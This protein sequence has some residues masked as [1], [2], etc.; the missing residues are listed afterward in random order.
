MPLNSL[1]TDEAYE[2]IFSHITQ[3]PVSNSGIFISFVKKSS[4]EHVGPQ[5]AEV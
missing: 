3:S 2:P 5:M 1:A 4:G